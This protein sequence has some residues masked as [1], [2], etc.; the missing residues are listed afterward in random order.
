MTVTIE[1]ASQQV[2][3]LIDPVDMLD[4]KFP[5]GTVF[6]QYYDGEPQREFY[7]HVGVNEKRVVSIW[8][9]EEDKEHRLSTDSK[10]SLRNFVPSVKVRQID[11]DV[12]IGLVG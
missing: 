4:N 7:V 6:Q 10:K 1:V 12:V 2:G 11:A 9:D 8:Y 5:Y 3:E